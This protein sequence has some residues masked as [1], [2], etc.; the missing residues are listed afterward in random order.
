[1]S[2][3]LQLERKMLFKVTKG[4]FFEDNPEAKSNEKFVA[5]TS[6]EMKYVCLV[7]DYGSPYRN[8]GL[9]ERKVKA[10]LEGG[11]KMERDGKRPDKYAREV[12]N[13]KWPKVQDAIK[14][15]MGMQLDEDKELGD[16]INAQI[17]EMRDFL[18][19]PKENEQQWNIAIKILEKM[20]KILKD[21]KEVF[22][23]LEM[24]EQL[25][26]AS[27]SMSEEAEQP[28]SELELLND[29]EFGTTE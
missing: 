3:V 14:E 8:M 7:Y 12:M 26:E 19:R 23:I 28:I 1:M 15:F 9:Q 20:P 27:V 17:K 16:S 18:K 10:L 25:N 24:R 11:F 4:D 22:D 13:G 21:R 6:R 29:E 2:L 5:C